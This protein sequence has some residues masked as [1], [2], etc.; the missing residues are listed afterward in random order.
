MPATQSSVTNDADA[1]SAESDQNS[2]D[3]KTK[4][5]QGSFAACCGDCGASERAEQR[6]LLKQQKAQNEIEK[7]QLLGL[8]E[9]ATADQVEIAAAERWAASAVPV[10]ALQRAADIGNDEAAKEC[11]QNMKKL[12]GI[13]KFESGW[14]SK[15]YCEHA[16]KKAHMMPT[17]LI[18]SIIIS[19]APEHCR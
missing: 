10:L 8:A 14:A 13:G 9:D 12:G 17:P 5:S 6:Q 1:T 2:R 3:K 19:A 16:L 7:K 4:E 11:V 18:L 15:R